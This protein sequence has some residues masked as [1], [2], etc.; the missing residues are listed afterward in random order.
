MSDLNGRLLALAALVAAV[1]PTKGFSEIVYTFENN[2]ILE[3]DEAADTAIFPA[4]DLSGIVGTITTLE[5]TNANGT[6][7]AQL[8]ENKESLGVNSVGSELDGARFDGQES[9]KF[10]WDVDTTLDFI[11]FAALTDDEVFLLHSPDWV[12]NAYD[13]SDDGLTFDSDAGEFAFADNGND[14]FDLTSIITSD[15]LLVSANT[16]YTLSFDEGTANDPNAGIEAFTFSAPTVSSSATGV[17]EPGSAAALLGLAGAA[18]GRRWHRNRKS[19]QT[20]A[21]ENV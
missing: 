17:P 10:S 14:Q 8:N 3:N 9:W 5:V 1:N 7:G 12:G 16:P 6:E 15:S 2:G 13:D 11:D 4:D 19:R 18:L 21:L 20:T